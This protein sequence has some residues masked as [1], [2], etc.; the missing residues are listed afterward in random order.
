MIVECGVMRM[1][2]ATRMARAMKRTR[3]A[4]GLVRSTSG[5]IQV[6][7]LKI[8]GVREGFIYCI[9]VGREVAM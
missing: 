2:S 4:S 7:E 3:G 6:D 1:T 8:V 5:K 9:S